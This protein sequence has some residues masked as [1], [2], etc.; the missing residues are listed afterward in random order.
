MC[1]SMKQLYDRIK[2][3]I[4][5]KFNGKNLQDKYSAKDFDELKILE[6]HNCI[7]TENNNDYKFIEYT[8]WDKTKK[9]VLQ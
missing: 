1:S 5:D 8:C 7:L 4:K 9:H 6:R 3:D 2:N